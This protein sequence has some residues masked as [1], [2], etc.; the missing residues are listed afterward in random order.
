[1]KKTARSVD[2]AILLL[3]ETEQI[4]VKRLRALIRECLPKAVEEP[5]Y[6]SGVP[7][8]T[9][10]RMICFIWPSSIYW[11]LKRKEE[12]KKTKRVTLG[13]CQ[14]NRMSNEDGILKSEGR[15]QVYCMYINSVTGMDEAQIRA[16]L[17]EAELIDEGFSRKRTAKKVKRQHI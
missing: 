10:R 6:G 3:P 1:M 17:F 14:G 16:M 8:Y 9:G 5:K 13:F 7:F 15:K 4:I 2:E 12:T 11:G